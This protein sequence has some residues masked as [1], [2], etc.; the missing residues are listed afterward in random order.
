M[1]PQLTGAA[2]AA[3]TLELGQQKAL[4]RFAGGDVGVT[5]EVPT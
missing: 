4:R 3:V 2:A 1:L 5:D